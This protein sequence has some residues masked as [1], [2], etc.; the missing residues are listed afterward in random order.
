MELLIFIFSCPSTI[1]LGSKVWKVNVSTNSSKGTPYCSP[2]ETAIAKQPST[3][4][5]VAPSLAISMN[6]S[7][8]VPSGYSPVRRY[9][10]WPAILASCVH[11]SLLSGRRNLG[12][13]TPAYALEGLVPGAKLPWINM[14][15]SSRIFVTSGS[16]SSE[17][18][19][20]DEEESGWEALEPS[21]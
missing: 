8:R 10:L 16:D 2:F 15:S 12:L 3:P 11:P 20:S 17:S 4:L 1:P 7:P 9:T 21:L 19:S 5:R 14:A 6:T 13:F 18:P